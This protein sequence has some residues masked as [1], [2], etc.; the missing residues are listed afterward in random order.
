MVGSA[1]G[2]GLAVCMG[3]SGIQQGAQVTL[4]ISIVA[5]AR[6]GTV[7]GIKRGRSLPVKAGGRQADKAEADRLVWP[8]N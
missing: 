7:L 3:G 6:Q 2:K 8:G 1:R 5:G 4:G